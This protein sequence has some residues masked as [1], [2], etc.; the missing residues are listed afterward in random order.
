MV[1]YGVCSSVYSTQFACILD[2]LL[3]TLR[4]SVLKDI[5]LANQIWTIYT[6]IKWYISVNVFLKMWSKH[7]ELFLFFFSKS[8]V[9][10][11]GT[12]KKSVKDTVAQL[13][14]LKKIKVLWQNETLVNDGNGCHQGGG[15]ACTVRT[16]LEP[17]GVVQMCEDSWLHGHHV[18]Q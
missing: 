10:R 9:K 1:L 14:H 16:K 4:Y 15:Q 12:I 2:V 3:I 8:C 13:S 5:M 6:Y 17:W 11:R 18:V 7:K